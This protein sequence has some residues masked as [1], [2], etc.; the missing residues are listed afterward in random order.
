MPPMK[1]QA[2]PAPTPRA[3]ALSQVG[4][5]QNTAFDVI[6]DHRAFLR[7]GTNDGL[8]RYDGRT[9]EVRAP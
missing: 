3:A 5:P 2:S 4:L 9:F 7:V 6:Q 1:K 8:A